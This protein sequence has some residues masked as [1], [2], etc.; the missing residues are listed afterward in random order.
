M[1]KKT[2]AYQISVGEG[3]LGPENRRKSES[4]AMNDSFGN[5]SNIE[6]E[7]QE[8]DHEEAGRLFNIVVIQPENPMPGTEDPEE[9]DVDLASR[10]DL[11]ESLGP[12][13]SQLNQ[14]PGLLKTKNASGNRVKFSEEVK[15]ETT[16]HNNQGLAEDSNLKDSMITGD[17]SLTQPHKPLRTGLHLLEEYFMVAIGSSFRKSLTN[18]PANSVV[19]FT[20]GGTYNH[21]GRR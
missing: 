7:N 11:R 15:E 19:K 8:L 21:P 4:E 14:N 16:S 5:L 12:I 13:V 1:E 17:V 2:P 18:Y 9:P 6:N 3:V 20:L 10:D